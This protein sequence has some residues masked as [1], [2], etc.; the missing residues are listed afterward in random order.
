[1][2]FTYGGRKVRI[3]YGLL[4]THTRNKVVEE[5]FSMFMKKIPIVNIFPK[6]E[7]QGPLWKTQWG[8]YIKCLNPWY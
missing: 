3:I 6:S 1:M 5:I 8:I 7:R 4:R 2:H